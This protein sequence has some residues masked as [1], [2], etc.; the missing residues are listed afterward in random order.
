[1]AT[2][3]KRCTKTA[4]G[5][6]LIE[7]LVAAAVLGLG[8]LSATTLAMHSLNASAANRQQITALAMANNAVECWRSGP[9]LCPASAPL[10]GGG[11]SLS[12]TTL[13]GSVYTVQSGVS[14]VLD[15]KLQA[16][17]VTVRWRPTSNMIG[18]GS[19]AAT[20]ADNPMA[21]GAGQ[22]RISTRVSWVPVFVA[23]TS[24]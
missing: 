2:T 4:H 14:W 23:S 5:F 18:N 10:S 3:A 7:A 22:L 9:V 12:T 19:N 24:P 20:R 16:I 11:D 13:G 17:E 6:T 21:P 1:M 8:I 15:A